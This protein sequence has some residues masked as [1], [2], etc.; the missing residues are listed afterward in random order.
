M[1]RWGSWKSDVVLQ[2]ASVAFD[3]SLEE[4]FVPY[5]VG[6]TLKVATAELIKETDRLPEIL[7]AEGIT[8]IDTVPTLLSMFE[9]DVPCLRVIVLGGETCPQALVDRFAKP[10]RRLLNT[11][12]PTETTVV[13]TYAELPPGDPVTIGRPIAN[14]TVYVVNDQLEPVGAGEVGELLVGGP[15]VAQGYINLPEMTRRKFIANPFRTD[16]LDEVLYRTGD[17][18]SIDAHGRLAYHGRIDDQVKIR[19]YRIEL[20]EIEMLIADEPGIKMAAVVVQQHRCGRRHAGRAFRHQRRRLRPRAGKEFARRQAAAVH[21]AD[22]LA[23][24]CGAAPARIRQ[25]RSQGARKPSGGPRCAGRRAGG[26]ELGD[27]GASAGC[28]QIGVRPGG[29]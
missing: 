20:G 27:G 9:R 1:R 29:G 15:G 28:R 10:G 25:G 2:Q 4:I 5:L 3:L 23:H 24:P 17:A 22:A 7:E 8:V 11:Y 19:G 12:G 6:A 21:G 16:G 18:V 14:H 26:A 13:A